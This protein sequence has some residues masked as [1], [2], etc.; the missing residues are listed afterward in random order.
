[1]RS[2]SESHVEAVGLL[3]QSHDGKA[4]AASFARLVSSK[5]DVQYSPIFY[6]ESRARDLLTSARRLVLGMDDIVRKTA[7]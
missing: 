6:G 5:T 2:A 1:M 7:P 3:K 4:L